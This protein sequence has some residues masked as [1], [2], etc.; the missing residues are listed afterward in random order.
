MLLTFE[1]ILHILTIHPVMLVNELVTKSA[2]FSTNAG[3]FPM[4]NVIIF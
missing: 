3:G 2:H 4:A 1:S